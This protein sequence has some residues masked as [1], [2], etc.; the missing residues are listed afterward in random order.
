VDLD[1]PTISDD[2]QIKLES[3]PQTL[4]PTFA[5]Y[6]QFWQSAAII[7]TVVRRE[8]GMPK[9]AAQQILPAL[10]EVG[11]AACAARQ[12][13]KIEGGIIRLRIRFAVRSPPCIGLTFHG[14]PVHRSTAPAAPQPIEPHRNRTSSQGPMSGGLKLHAP[15]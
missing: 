15:R 5:Q 4:H 1:S 8:T 3:H 9:K 7:S 6:R 14:W 11:G 2:V 13:V 12:G 10:H